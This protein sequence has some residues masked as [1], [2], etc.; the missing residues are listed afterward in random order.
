LFIAWHQGLYINGAGQPANRLKQKN[1]P[2]KVLVR[3][4]MKKQ[5]VA[6]AIYT[7]GSW[8]EFEVMQQWTSA[9]L[10]LS[11]PQYEFMKV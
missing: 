1:V 2:N 8:G 10:I 4:L 11:E 7:A 5:W 6:R 9:I 3:L